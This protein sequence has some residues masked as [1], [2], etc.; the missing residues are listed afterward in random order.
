[1]LVSFTLQS[2][3]MKKSFSMAAAMMAAAVLSI[4]SFVSCDDEDEKFES[5]TFTVELPAQLGTGYE[6]V[7][8]NSASAAADSV[9]KSV[10]HANPDDERV[11]GPGVEK[12]SFKTKENGEEVL[13]FTYMRRWEES[14]ALKDTLVTF[15]K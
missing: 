2:I 13:K 4:S 9:S 7:W 12:W 6:W 3:F 8:T 1:M 11:G 14:T 15:K 5:K 10:N